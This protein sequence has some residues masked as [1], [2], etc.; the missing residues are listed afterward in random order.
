M[1]KFRKNAS[2][3]AKKMNEIYGSHKGQVYKDSH[4]QQRG[5]K[6]ASQHQWVAVFWEGK[7]DM[8]V[9]FSGCHFASP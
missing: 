5:K 8:G 1:F 9:P 6:R 3:Y 7:W 2:S 4:L